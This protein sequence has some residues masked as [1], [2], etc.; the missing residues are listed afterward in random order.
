MRVAIYLQPNDDTT[1]PVAWNERVYTRK[2][3]PASHQSPLWGAVQSSA[4]SETL[5]DRRRVPSVG[6]LA[7]G[8]GLLSSGNDPDV[9]VLPTVHPAAL[10][11][12][13]EI[14][15]RR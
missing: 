2:S 8:A 5:R 6:E 1:V 4:T 12:R 13:S 7:K 9:R 14:V 11:N 15:L 10:Q 3:Q